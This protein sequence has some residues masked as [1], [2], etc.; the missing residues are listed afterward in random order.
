MMMCPD[1]E[2]VVDHPLPSQ[3]REPPEAGKRGGS[4]L[5]TGTGILGI[6]CPDYIVKCH[7]PRH[8]SSHK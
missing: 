4:V 5:R 8:V 1:V 2:A 3:L 7:C 6:G